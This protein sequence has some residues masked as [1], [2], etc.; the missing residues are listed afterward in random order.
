MI[1]NIV[2]SDELFKKNAWSVNFLLPDEELKVK[3]GYTLISLSNLVKERKETVLLKSGVSHYVGLEN[4]ESMTGRLV[5]YRERPC[6][7][8][9]SICKKFYK[10]DILFGRLRPNLNKVFFNNVIDWGECSTEILVLQPNQNIV[11]PLFLSELL[12]SEPIYNKII[13]IVKGA[14]LPRVSITDL[15]Q[16]KIPIPELEEQNKIVKV[17]QRK[18]EELEEHIK[19]AK[20][21]PSDISRLLSDSYMKSV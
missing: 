20:Q 4:I 1:V 11:E 3:E 18:R 6:E 10:G 21:I 5:D 16:I 13:K 8:I 9:K 15:C 7:D 14:S 12:R 2:N 17:I 19:L